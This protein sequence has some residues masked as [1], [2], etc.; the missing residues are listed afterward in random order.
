MNTIAVFVR[1]QATA[2]KNADRHSATKAATP[3][4]DVIKPENHPWGNQSSI[5]RSYVKYAVTQD[6]RQRTATSESRNKPTHHLDKSQTRKRTTQKTGIAEEISKNRVCRRD[7]KKRTPLTQLEC[8]TNSN[9]E[10]P[11]D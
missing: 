2:N 4:E 6:T 3:S 9:N 5:R 10:Y 11:S 7:L 8:E 1:K